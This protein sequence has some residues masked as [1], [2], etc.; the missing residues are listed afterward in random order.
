VAKEIME[1]DAMLR[2]KVI[3]VKDYV[4]L[5]LQDSLEKG[6]IKKELVEVIRERGEEAEKIIKL[7]NARKILE[8]VQRL[9]KEVFREGESDP[10][11]YIKG[12]RIAHIDRKAID[13]IEKLSK[14]YG[15]ETSLYR[16]LL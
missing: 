13:T 7:I 14:R 1:R 4:Y 5:S 9:Q 15:R 6:L 11:Q 3:D 2:Y 12:K 16:Y 8:E 10:L